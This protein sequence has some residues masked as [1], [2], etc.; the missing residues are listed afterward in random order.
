LI[1]TKN[2]KTVS[3]KCFGKNYASYAAVFLI[4]KQAREK[5]LSWQERQQLREE[6]TPPILNEFKQWLLHHLTK[7]PMQ[8]K[9][10]KAIQ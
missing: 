7:I 6:K 4:E 5:N 9:I 10:G 1:I 3:K 8:H 2:L